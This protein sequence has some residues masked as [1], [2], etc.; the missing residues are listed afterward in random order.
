VIDKATGWPKFTAILNKTSYH[1]AILFDSVWLCHY[2]RLARVVYD[3]GIEFVGQEFQELS[4]SYGIKAIPKIVRNP[5]SNGVIE[6]VHPTMGDMLRTITFKG[7]DWFQD[8]Q[9]ALDAVAWAVRITINPN[10]KHFPIH[11]AFNQ[12][13]IFHR[14]VE[15]NWT[16][17][18]QE[19]QR[20]GSASNNK[21]NKSRLDKQYAPGDQVLMVLDA[22]K[23]HSQPKMSVH[24][25]G[26]FTITQVNSNGT[27]QIS[28]GNVSENYQHP[29]T[30]TL[31]YLANETS[32][33]KVPP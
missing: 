26:P 8:M 16:A 17:I 23:W 2:P 13:M 10:I 22:D 30:Q 32:S 9:R 28:H 25:K 6:Q 4:R 14:A 3:N 7:A 31:L 11:L 5:K 27:V 1:I 18:H 21:E 29:L 12:D 33:C 19:R 24:T 15:I 20:L